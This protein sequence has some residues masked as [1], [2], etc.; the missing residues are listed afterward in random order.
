[1]VMLDIR[2][3][4]EDKCWFQTIYRYLIFAVVEEDSKIFGATLHNG[5]RSIVVQDEQR[6]SVV[7]DSEKEPT[8]FGAY[9]RV[10]FE[11]MM[12]GHSMYWVPQRSPMIKEDAKKCRKTSKRNQ[13]GPYK[14]P[15]E[16][17]GG[18]GDCIVMQIV[19]HNGRITVSSPKPCATG[20]VCL[21]RCDKSK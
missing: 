1:M 3:F 4:I 16:T 19:A 20:T 2:F 9:V 10:D 11:Q 6:V 18:Y 5:V 17:S 14:W 8:S 13:D 21:R 15:A 7:N 12:E